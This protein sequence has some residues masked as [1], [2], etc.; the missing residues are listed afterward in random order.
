MACGRGAQT[1]RNVAALPCVRPAMTT[2]M[3][4]SKRA[5]KPDYLVMAEVLENIARELRAQ[6]ERNPTARELEQAVRLERIAA[7][8]RGD[9]AA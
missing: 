4:S 9:D 3:T 2:K 1:V 8:I 5:D 6:A 7:D